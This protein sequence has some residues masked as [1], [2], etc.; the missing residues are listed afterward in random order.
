MTNYIYRARVKNNGESISY[1]NSKGKLVTYKPLEVCG[2]R[3]EAALLF[4]T[5]NKYFTG[6]SPN[7]TPE[8]QLKIKTDIAKQR[9][10]LHK[11]L[12]L[13][14]YEGIDFV[15]KIFSDKNS[16]GGENITPNEVYQIFE[17]FHNWTKSTSGNYT[18]AAKD[19]F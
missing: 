9:K 17:I 15:F 13:D 10:P 11:D 12:S 2:R 3:K 8:Q 16:E 14:I 5:V 7:I 1:H 19:L 4:N 6:E 18:E